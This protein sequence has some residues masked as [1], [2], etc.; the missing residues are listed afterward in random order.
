MYDGLNDY[1]IWS[2]TI[3]QPVASDKDLAEV[4]P[5]VLGNHRAR[6]WEQ[7]NPFNRLEQTS[8][9]R[10]RILRRI[11]LNVSRNPINIPKS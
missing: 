8:N 6:F 11:A 5:L 3:D 2:V 1:F 9:E 4:V 7:S 10:S